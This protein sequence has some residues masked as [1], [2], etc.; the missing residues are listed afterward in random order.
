MG[1]L[2]LQSRLGLSNADRW[3]NAA[4]LAEQDFMMVIW[5]VY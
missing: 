2:R 4:Y 1:M 3:I 5:R